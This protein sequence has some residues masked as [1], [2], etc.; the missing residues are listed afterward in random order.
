MRP[1]TILEIKIDPKEL[2]SLFDEWQKPLREKYSKVMESLTSRE[3]EALGKYPHNTISAMALSGLSTEKDF[4]DVIRS[5]V[6]EVE[7][8]PKGRYL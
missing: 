2:A 6:E 8:Q 1:V 7:K 5:K 3:L 4:G